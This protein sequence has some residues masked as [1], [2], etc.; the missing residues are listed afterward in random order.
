MPRKRPKTAA[1]R[2]VYRPAPAPIVPG[3][4]EPYL[5]G[6]EL[7]RI[8]ERYGVANLQLA[9]SLIAEQHRREMVER[10]S[11][12]IRDAWKENARPLGPV[13]IPA[14]SGLRSSRDARNSPRYRGHR[15]EHLDKLIRIQQRERELEAGLAVIMESNADSWKKKELADIVHRATSGQ[16]SAEIAAALGTSVRTIE[17]RLS[18]LR[19]AGVSKEELASS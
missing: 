2:P 16:T 15:E 5:D 9:L 18:E 11:Q 12:E 1:D 6:L 4:L 19:Q 17:N 10:R 13:R 3:V 14:L 8:V 7:R